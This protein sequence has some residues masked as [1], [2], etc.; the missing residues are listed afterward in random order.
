L[1][2]ASF[3]AQLGMFV[4]PAFLD[5]ATCSGLRRE[6]SSSQTSLAEIRDSQNHF[7]VDEAQRK[8][9]RAV[10]TCDTRIRVTSLLM[11]LLPSLETHFGLKLTGCEP[12]SFLV[13]KE[14]YHFH[15]HT[16][17]TR[18]PSAPGQVRDRRVSL[19][20]FLNGEGGGEE[21]LT[22]GGGSLVFYGAG[23]D[24]PGSGRLGIPLVGEEGLL[25]GFRS[26]WPHSVQPV[27]RG[28]RYSV[29]TWFY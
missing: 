11:S 21:P 5:S 29:V 9:E 27:S 17:S 25:I 6:M 8:V 18:D 16:D 12:I 15:A 13:Y 7:R 20:V 28:T 14:G 22:Y 19:S 1:P 2:R 3:F 26:D 4:V 23:G 10:V 24:R